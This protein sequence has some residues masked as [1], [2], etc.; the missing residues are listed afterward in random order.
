MDRKN[1]RLATIAM[2]SSSDKQSNIT[3]ACDYIRQA[4]Q[5]GADWVLLP[6]MFS[7]MG[8]ESEIIEASEDE[9][10][11]LNLTLSAL[12]KDL[13]ITIFAGS[14]PEKSHS[15]DKR[16]YNTLY[17]FD[18][19]GEVIAKYRKI[20]LFSLSNESG[21]ITHDEGLTFL[22][23]NHLVSFTHQG[24][25]V[26]LAICY[27]LR[28]PEFFSALNKYKTADIIIIPAAFTKRTGSVHW[29]T[30]LTARAIENQCYVF[31]SNQT[32]IHNKSKES[33]G[34]SLIIDPWGGILTD[35]KLMCGPFYA[36]VSKNTITT[37]RSQLPSLQHK[38]LD[39]Y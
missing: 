35:S 27:D 13:D 22:P 1:I 5:G 34:H 19:T 15:T 32:G 33:Y 37:Y 39:L 28:F 24:W 31:S 7:C 12:A 14:C 18:P 38:C 23:G 10:G 9:S 29:Q 11:P 17:V 36:D 30:L 26:A 16:V 4:A 3:L 8:H 6:E 21:Q 25:T 20:H 2:N